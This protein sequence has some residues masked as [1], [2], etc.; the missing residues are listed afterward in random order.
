MTTG[1]DLKLRTSVT[2][3][4]P[5]LSKIQSFKKY[6]KSAFL[7]TNQFRSD[8]FLV[9]QINKYLTELKRRRVDQREED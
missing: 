7:F 3:V 5:L 4:T 2:L 1:H 9:G 8:T 6:H